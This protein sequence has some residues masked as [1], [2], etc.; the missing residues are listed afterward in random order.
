MAD[1]VEIVGIKEELRVSNIC[2]RGENSEEIYSF[3]AGQPRYSSIRQGIEEA[4]YSYFASLRLPP[5]LTLYDHLVLSLREKDLIATFN[6]D[7]FLYF[8]CLRNH[9]FAKPPIASICMEALQ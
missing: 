3:I 7:P 6:W 4:I 5:E 1:L 8:A 9:R 2:Y